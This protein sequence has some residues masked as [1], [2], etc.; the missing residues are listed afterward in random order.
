MTNTITGRDLPANIEAEKL[1]LGSIL[2]DSQQF[3]LVAGVLS[4]GDFSIERHRRIFLRMTDLNTRGEKIDRV[5]VVNELRDKGELDADG[6]SYVASLDDG[7][8][9]IP[10]LDSYVR[11]VQEKA[12]LRRAIIAAESLIDRCMLARDGAQ[13]ILCEAGGILSKLADRHGNEVR[14]PNPGDVMTSFPGGINSFLMPPRNGVGAETPWPR[15]TASLC[16]LHRGDL[17]LVA[18]R[19]SMGKSIVG[20]QL[21]HHAAG[22]GEGVAVFSLEMTEDSLI[23]RLISAVGCVDAQR[24]RAGRLDAAERLK[25]LTAASQIKGL[26][27]FIDDSRA[28]TIPAVTSAL[29]KLIAKHPIRVV[30]VDHLQLM[31]SM[32]RVENRHQE[33]SEISHSL[34]NLAGQF[35][36]TVIL[37]SQLNRE[38]EREAR[39][40]RLADLKETGSLEEDADVVLFVHR[41][42][43]YNRQDSTLRGRAEFIIGK[44]RNG[45]TGKLAMR[46]QHE[47]QRFVE[48]TS[49]EAEDVE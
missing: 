4:S 49:A 43:Q 48:E 21:A 39:R 26:P 47:Y 30:V 46:F 36:V 23:R 27:L 19:P 13:E 15:L 1:V 41:P 32:G 37:L 3:D 38:C 11:I 20:M 40:P 8:P 42:E 9:R 29:R 22:L 12:T 28:R 7:L 35:N 34:K 17:F 31:R 14:W 44:Q 10:N 24:F 33:L 25:V 6:I 5:T 16:G 45:P 2:N 18:G